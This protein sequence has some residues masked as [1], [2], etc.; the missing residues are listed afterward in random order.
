MASDDLRLVAIAVAYPP[1]SGRGGRA[2]P[3]DQVLLVT[4]L[5]GRRR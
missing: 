5:V 3:V 1:T 4:R 2:A